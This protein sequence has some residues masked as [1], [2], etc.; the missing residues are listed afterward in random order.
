MALWD[1][2]V[3]LSL[4]RSIVYHI[5]RR[6]INV[7]LIALNFY[8]DKFTPEELMGICTWLNPNVCDVIF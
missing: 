1:I 5:G 3:S 7:N 4:K 8:Y 6:N 2:N